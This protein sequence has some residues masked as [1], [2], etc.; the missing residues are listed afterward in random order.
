MKLLHG[1]QCWE[2]EMLRKCMLVNPNRGITCYK[3]A[4]L[5]ALQMGAFL[6]ISQLS[7]S[8]VAPS[9]LKKTKQK[10]HVAGIQ[11]RMRNECT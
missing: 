11:I 10:K 4:C 9:Q 1:L 5:T 7:Q 8:L 2:T 6:S 3:L